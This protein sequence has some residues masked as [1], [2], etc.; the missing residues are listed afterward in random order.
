MMSQSHFEV[1]VVPR[2]V[3]NEG[4]DR[5]RSCTTYRHYLLVQAQML[6]PFCHL[7][8]DTFAVDGTF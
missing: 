1:L 8:S 3:E 4:E 6:S 5:N 7:A 2:V